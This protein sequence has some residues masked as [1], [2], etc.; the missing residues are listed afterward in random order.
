MEFRKLTVDADFATS[1]FNRKDEKCF[2]PHLLH[3]S[4]VS[5]SE[6][7]TSSIGSLSSS[8]SSSLCDDDALS[9]FSSSSSSS[10]SLLSQ[11][12]VCEEQQLLSIKKGLSKFYEGKS[13]TFSSLSDVK[14]VE[15]LA[16]GDN[17]YRKKYSR[18]TPKATI[19]KKH[20]R[21]SLATLASKMDISLRPE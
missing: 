6:D 3:F 11:R 8:S 14:C 1:L 15:D 20:G 19:L 9:S 10:S 18:I 16:K 17:D 12:E 4:D 7:S 5:C 2:I 13:R 21:A